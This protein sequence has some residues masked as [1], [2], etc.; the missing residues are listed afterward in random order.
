MG[1]DKGRRKPT[2]GCIVTSA[3][4]PL[5]AISVACFAAFIV[6][7]ACGA[8]LGAAMPGLSRALGHSEAR[9]GLAFSV[10]GSGFLAATL[11]SAA[12]MGVQ[13]KPLSAEV[14][15]TLGAVLMGA[16]TFCMAMTDS[17][18]LV[19]ALSVFQGMGFGMIDTLSN[20]LLPE[21]WRTRIGPWMQGLH[22][23]YGIGAMIGPGLVGYVGYQ[24]TYIIIGCAAF[25]PLMGLQGYRL[26][27]RMLYGADKA[28]AIVAGASAGAGGGDRDRDYS[29]ASML[30]DD[31]LDLQDTM[32]DARTDSETSLVEMGEPEQHPVPPLLRYAITLF[33]FFYGGCESGYAGWIVV[34]A[35]K[36]GLTTSESG[37]THLASVFWAGLT[38]GRLLSIITAMHFT[39]TALLRTHLLASLF[40]A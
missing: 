15:T 22:M 37:A 2:P 26:A 14:L 27:L 34:F 3:D 21:L 28:N 4:T 24:S 18:S 17:Y 23:C 25:L 19:M 30:E 33:Y 38:L 32:F 10:R 16:A 9:V 13:R 31:E 8:A 11:G 39:A 40:C 36:V 6:Y 12:I 20:C 35:L 1:E 29:A 7:G 5:V